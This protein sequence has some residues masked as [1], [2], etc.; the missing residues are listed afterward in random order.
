MCWLSYIGKVNCGMPSCETNL[1]QAVSQMTLNKLFNYFLLKIFFFP[2]MANQKTVVF[3]WSHRLKI[4]EWSPDK[5]A[6]VSPWKSWECA[7]CYYC[8]RKWSWG[9]WGAYLCGEFC[10]LH[11]RHDARRDFQPCLQFV[12]VSGWYGASSTLKG[13]TQTVKCMVY[14]NI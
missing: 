12:F 14:C 10:L 13:N 3:S 9:S 4:E 7:M 2:Q 1:Y 6:R 5:T 11:F 8:P